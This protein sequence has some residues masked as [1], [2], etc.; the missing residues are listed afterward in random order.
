MTINSLGLPN[1]VKGR[2]D[3]VAPSSGDIG[4]VIEATITDTTLTTTIGDVGGASIT[5]T[6]GRWKITYE[7]SALYITGT[8][9]GD[10]GFTQAI[11]TDSSNVLIAKTERLLNGK[12]PAAAEMRC[13]ATL[14]AS[15]FLNLSAGATYK[16]RGKVT[17][18]AGTG[19]GIILVS[20]STYN[21]VFYA[22][23]IG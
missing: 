15:A 12:T 20:A 17:N 14:T 9:A 11:M 8:A 23:R 5:L 2:T 22:Q 16:V 21:S 7:L 6:P 4:E 10:N 1:G 19:S 13:A 3:G 18:N